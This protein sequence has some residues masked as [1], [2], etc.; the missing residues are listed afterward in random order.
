MEHLIQKVNNLEMT[1]RK[2]VTVKSMKYLRSRDKRRVNDWD[3]YF[4]VTGWIVPKK[5]FQNAK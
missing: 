4:L 2:D 3:A 5:E 1:E